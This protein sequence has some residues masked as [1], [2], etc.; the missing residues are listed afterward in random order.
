M[1]LPY[2]KK[3][4]WEPVVL[5]VKP[6]HV[7]GVH[8]SFLAQTLPPD[9]QVVWSNALS[10]KW[11]RRF[12]IG[13][14]AYRAWGHLKRAG[15]ALLQREKFDLIFFSTTQFPLTALGPR[16]KKLFNVPYVLDFQDPWFSDYYKHHPERRPPGGKVKYQLSNILAKRLEPLVVR[17][18]K[19]IICV[20]AAYPKMLNRRY[21]D[22]SLDRF[23]TL[24]FGAVESD[25]EFLRANPLAQKQ[26]DPRDGKRH[27]VY[28]GRGG[29]DM[30]VSL[31]AFFL[32]LKQV[33]ATQPELHNKLRI[34]F[35]GTDYAPHGR[36][37]K[38]VEPLAAEFGLGDIMSEGTD[39]IPYFEALQCLLDADALFIP[40]SD[41]AGYTASKTY[42]Y[43]LARKPL[44]AVF[45]EESSVVEVLNNT[46]AGTVVSFKQEDSLETVVNKILATGWL[47][48]RI[49]PETDWSAFERYT[50]CEMSRRLC[51]AFGQTSDE[52]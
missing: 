48:N 20:S 35:I 15:D 45:H 47:Q 12:G 33:F 52:N 2:F 14:L 3:F 17:E 29:N 6:E 49:V 7:E 46:R 32:A 30:A 31:K 50:A 51:E 4:G 44:L 34:H 19:H 39:R 22:V 41:D 27:W 9:L 23:T 11:T 21:P 37:T 1:A 13:S 5:A 36:G 16:W 28:V 24:P 42:P 8:D 43:I 25:F 26:F 10:A 38:T 18:A 40:G